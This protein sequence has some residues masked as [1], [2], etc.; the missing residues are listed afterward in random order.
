MR[1]KS[2][3]ERVAEQRHAE[4]M[5][6][7][8]SQLARRHREC[9]HRRDKPCRTPGCGKGVNARSVDGRCFLCRRKTARI[10]RKGRYGPPERLH[11]R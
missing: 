3:A 11:A 6:E 9:G 4:L 1:A 2:L 8:P 5:E 10:E 7:E